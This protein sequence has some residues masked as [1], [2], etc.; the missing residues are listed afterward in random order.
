MMASPR[1]VFW[2]FGLLGYAAA[3]WFTLE[4]SGAEPSGNVEQGRELFA[5]EWVVGDKRSVAGDGL[6]PVYNDRSC[7]SCHHQGGVGGGG[8]IDRNIE[9]A[10]ANA[11]GFASGGGF[12]YSF[13]M[14][15]GDAGFH[16]QIGNPN[17]STKAQT[18][19]IDLAQLVAIHP[20]F[21]DG[22]S[23]VLH[24]YG[25]D[26]NYALYRERVPG[27]HGTITI[28]TSLRNPPPLFGAGLIDAIPDDVLITAS[29]KRFTGSF[30][31]I[32]GRVNRLPDGRLGRFGW[33]AQTATL[34]EFV[35]SAAANEM[36]LELPDQHQG[37]DPRFP[38]L[39]ARGVD[40]SQDECDSL[41]AYV[42]NL[43]AP[44]VM[45]PA[46]PKAEAQVK[47]GASIFKSIGCAHCHVPKLGDL[48]G[49]YSDLL[50]HEMSPTLSDTG[51]YG[52]FDGRPDAPPPP[53]RAA[54]PRNEPGAKLGEWRT[55]PLWGL[56]NSAPYLH[57]GRAATIDQAITL[58]GGQGTL[59]AQRYARLSERERLQLEEFLVS[60]ASPEPRPAPAVPGDQARAGGK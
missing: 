56:R 17:P 2:R 43:P 59:S 50:L 37:A 42:A 25:P 5:R 11:A 26:V 58:H 47:A 31:A 35:L 19:P 32:K 54:N 16:Y 34:R 49:L 39:A 20:G 12:A 44:R 7:Q 60:L 40:M 41:I 29:K 18:P 45:A 52:V 51:S 46:D 15:F 22:R 6:G 33:K 36:G 55:P 53:A 1:Q 3:C 4:A 27:V 23:V 9:I 21:R 13:S 14:S 38:P 28:T 24:R 57:D 30:S 10:T 48:A 8:G